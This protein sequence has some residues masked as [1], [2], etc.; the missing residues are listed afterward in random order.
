MLH[1]DRNNRR[2]HRD[3]DRFYRGNT[4]NVCT[5]KKKI[6]KKKTSKIK[7]TRKTICKK[8]YRQRLMSLIIKGLLKITITLILTDKWL[9]NSEEI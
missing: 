1:K 4:Y 5:L 2:N 3:K 7:I 8:Y 6:I 9:N